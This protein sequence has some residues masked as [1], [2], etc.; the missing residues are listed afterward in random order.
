MSFRVRFPSH[1][2]LTT[3]DMHDSHR[4]LSFLTLCLSLYIFDQLLTVSFEVLVDKLFTSSLSLS[5]F[6]L[7]RFLRTFNLL[8]FYTLRFHS[9]LYSTCLFLRNQIKLNVFH[10]SSLFFSTLIADFSFNTYI[11]RRRKAEPTARRR[12]MARRRVRH[13]E[14]VSH[15]EKQGLR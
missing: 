15:S 14:M 4:C 7:P 3:Y 11:K 1:N 10:R 12:S 8:T 5:S 13:E 6:S 2:T 9:F